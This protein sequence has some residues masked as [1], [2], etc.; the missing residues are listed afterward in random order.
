M[1]EYYTKDEWVEM[2]QSYLGTKVGTDNKRFPPDACMDAIMRQ[3]NGWQPWLPADFQD[4]YTQYLFRSGFSFSS[5]AHDYVL[6]LDSTC[7]RLMGINLIGTTEQHFELYGL[8]RGEGSGD[9]NA[10]VD[11]CQRLRRTNMGIRL[12]CKIGKRIHTF[13]TLTD[14]LAADVNIRVYAKEPTQGYL[15]LY[16]PRLAVPFHISGAAAS[17]KW[18]DLRAQ[19]AVA[20]LSEFNENL[21]TVFSI[22]QVEQQ[23]S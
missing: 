1:N 5:S 17:G 2:L 6:E 8:D 18:G 20:L 14:N 16:I 11:R 7:A 3:I 4:T 12:F 23:G 9:Y 22:K 19:E 10:Y 13:P 21:K 15:P